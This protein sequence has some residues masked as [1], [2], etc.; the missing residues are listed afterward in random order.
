MGYRDRPSISP[1]TAALVA[2]GIIDPDRHR[3]LDLGCGVG[4][5][6]IALAEIG[7]RVVGVDQDAWSIERAKAA[8]R[9]PSFRDERLRF[10]QASVTRPIPSLEESS[11]DVALDTLTLY[12][13][14]GKERYAREIHR[15]LK[16]RGLLV[17]A[18]RFRM[19]GR[20]LHRTEIPDLHPHFTRRFAFPEWHLLSHIPEHPQRRGSPGQ[21]RVAIVVGRSRKRRR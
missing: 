16:P 3:V 4:T 15:L 14:R 13:V 2:S 5:D 8:G 7:C 21:A 1:V 9:Q 18:L 19:A 12:N 11:F 20:Y 6:A 10:I 17:L